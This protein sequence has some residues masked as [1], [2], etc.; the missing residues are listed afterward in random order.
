MRGVLSGRD[1]GGN[2]VSVRDRFLYIVFTFES[3]TYHVGKKN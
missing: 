1:T 3:I 2:V